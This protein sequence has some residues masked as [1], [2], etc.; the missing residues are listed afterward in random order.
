MGRRD[1]LGI[2]PTVIGHGNMPK[3]PCVL[4]AKHQSAWETMALQDT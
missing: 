1:L 3:E 4:L 2:R